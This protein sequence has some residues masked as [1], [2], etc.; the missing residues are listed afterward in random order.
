VPRLAKPRA[1]AAGATLGIAAPGGPVDPDRLAEGE[2][3]LVAA[4]YRTQ[5]RD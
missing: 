5:R 3:R 2:A 4:G 1:I